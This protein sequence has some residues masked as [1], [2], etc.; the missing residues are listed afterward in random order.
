[1]GITST[2]IGSGL[3]VTS[4][5]SSLIS[6]ERAG[7]DALLTKRSS[8]ANYKISAL[9][10]VRSA[11][12]NLQASIQ[13]LLTGK[14]LA[15]TKV[16]SSDEDI[17]T[18]TASTHATPGSY[19]V[20]V[21]QKAQA[22]KTISAAA[23]SSTAQLGAG[24]VTIVVG[25][26]A[27]TVT[28]AEGKSSLADLRDAINGASNNSG[29][30]AS[31]ITEDGG[32]RLVL[33]GTETGSENAISVT[34]TLTTFT[35]KQAATDSRIAIDGYTYTS[36]SNTVDGAIDGVT[37]NLLS[38][39]VGTI[40]DVKV[41]RD[42]GSAV[43]AV[44]GFV[45]AYNALNTTIKSNTKYDAAAK[46]AGA[47]IGDPS[48]RGAQQQLRQ[49]V[50]SQ[51]PASGD[52]S[53]LSDL[54]IAI[55]KD[56]LMSVD[57]VKLNEALDQDP[58]AVESLFGNDDGYATRIDT[59]MDRYLDEGDDGTSLLEGKVDALNDELEE[60]REATDQLDQRM[61]KR[62]AMYTKQFNAL[63]SVVNTYQNTMTY[64]DQLFAQSIRKD[65]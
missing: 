14:E 47:L 61:E 55:D 52:F 24:D 36:G 16:S 25:D 20:E 28:L 34:S 49:I 57:T 45:N 62:S 53:A 18:S 54:G 23:A 26:D 17:L 11:M 3:D 65:N 58:D 8:V 9:G 30:R 43:T 21:L 39:E 5:V 40:V 46:T 41:E 4:L 12:A 19:G 2:G 33:T 48:I 51:M 10:N 29:V 50:G 31:L 64:L 13:K 60:I 38:A 42:T 1:M 6:A 27:F 35:E 37:L 44:Q 7:T 15:K 56:G 63:D 59:L 22:G 32:T